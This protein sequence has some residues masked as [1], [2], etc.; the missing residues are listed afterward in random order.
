MFNFGTD[1]SRHHMELHSLLADIYGGKAQLLAY[2][3]ST[4]PLEWLSHTARRIRNG[5]LAWYHEMTFR[6]YATRVAEAYQEEGSTLNAYWTYY[7]AHRG[8]DRLAARYLSRARDLETQAIPEAEAFYAMRAAMLR[9]D[10][11]GIARAIEGMHPRWERSSIAE[12]LQEVALQA[13]DTG[14]H[15]TADRASVELYRVNHGG[16]RQHGLRLPVR[17]SVSGA[18]EAEGFAD[19]V[20]RF[21]TR[22][23]LRPAAGSPLRLEVEAFA[24]GRV[25]YRLVD[26]E[27]F[28]RGDTLEVPEL[29]RAGAATAAR[30]IS[31]A[32]FRVD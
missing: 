32:V 30:R 31:D 8:Y 22:A 5:V 20:E 6:R 29:N 15:E 9:D 14:D 21:L 27:R 7:R 12:G 13:R 4:G 10:R 19:A 23:G 16:L 2:R 18:A 25:S 24:D 17:L 11:T 3:P 26:E 28:L 1:E